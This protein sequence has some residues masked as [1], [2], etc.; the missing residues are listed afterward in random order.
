MSPLMKPTRDARG[1]AGADPALTE[2]RLLE[3]AGAVFAER[4]FRG[5]T[6]R[7]ICRRA[8][9]NVAAIHYHY[10]DKEALYA[11]VLRYGHRAALEKY[12]PDGGLPPDAPAEARLRAYVR[13]FLRRLLDE[14]EYAWAGQLLSREMA[15]PTPALDGVVQ[16]IRPAAERL[17]GI[18]RELAGPKAGS[19][20]LRRCAFS[21]VAECLF[22]RHARPVLDRL[23]P[24]RRYDEK[25]IEA[26][27]DH[28]VR[29][30][31]AG[32]RA[33]NSTPRHQ[34]TKGTKN[35]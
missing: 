18:V 23:D 1:P 10:G 35:K 22:Y 34:D 14:G 11:A 25:E 30:S 16:N 20:D 8:G 15:D 5:A 31:L 24:G 2:R 9:A 6:I 27:T 7:E 21:I 32:L 33:L 12:P 26:L 13:S 29:F 4:G 19:D 28:I 3:A 17:G